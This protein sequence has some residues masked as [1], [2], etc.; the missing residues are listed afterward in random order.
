VKIIHISDFHLVPPGEDLLGLDPRAR[1]S[2]M[3]DDIARWHGDADFCV[4]TGDMA[5]KG[6]IEAYGWLAERLGAFPL[7]TF[8][9]VGNHDDPA[10]LRRAM[11][12][13]P[14][15]PGGFLQYRHDCALGTFLFLDTYKGPTSEGQYCEARQAWLR[16]ELE[17]AAETGRA[18][19][20]FM[21]HPPFDVAIPYMDRIKLEEADAFGD[22]VRCH[23]NIRHIFFGHI[24]RAAY[25][26]WHGIGC[27][28][29]PAI[30]HQ[31][32]LVAASV[33]ANYSLEPA[34]YGVVLI[35]PD[36]MVIH[37]DAALDRRSPPVAGH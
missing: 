17:R 7:E 14:R 11:P 13:L 3:L 6:R 31:V 22:I 35:E 16:S 33:G 1:L 37:F 10:A 28:S 2:A 18:V 29:L 15:D 8:L 19:W 12:D 36:K 25:V 5:D 32:P 27:T 9:I 24:H 26:Q 23:T 30:C 4:I 20:I 21:H 34:M